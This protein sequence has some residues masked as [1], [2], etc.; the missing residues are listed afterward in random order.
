MIPALV[1]GSVV[2]HS[3]PPSYSGHCRTR[4]IGSQAD[5]RLRHRG[6]VHSVFG[7]ACNL[8]THED[9]LVSLVTPSVGAGPVN[10]VLDVPDGADFRDEGL[11]VGQAVYRSGQ[12]LRIGRMTVELDA[13]EAWSPL[14]AKVRTTPEVLI[15]SLAL[16]ESYAGPMPAGD[17]PILLR[18][19]DARVADFAD[20]VARPDED[21]RCDAARALV[22][23]G[24]GLTPAGDDFLAGYA[25]G[26]S[27][28]AATWA[29]SERRLLATWI[30]LGATS[31]LSG[32]KLAMVLAGALDER[33]SNATAAILSGD[34]AMAAAIHQLTSVGH[35]SGWFTVAGICASA[36]LALSQASSGT[37]RS[38]PAGQGAREATCYG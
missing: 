13:A 7:R 12:L 34:P 25:A 27:M 16:A 11:L 38:M 28:L 20:A 23:L 15:V 33:L 26:L 32:Q 8:V 1:P 18:A 4:Y 14:L 2:D 6:R 21:A 22:G 3:A 29:S 35:T 19:M 30:D 31:W 17:S 36:R 37:E 5:A 9:L 10:V 24:P